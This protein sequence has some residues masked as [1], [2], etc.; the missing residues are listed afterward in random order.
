MFPFP[1]FPS[2]V[3]PLNV[4]L[5]PSQVPSPVFPLLLYLWNPIPSLLVLKM[6]K[7]KHRYNQNICILKINL[8]NKPLRENLKSV[9]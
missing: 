9:A 2:T 7:K 3:F 4:H 8:I 5:I 6:K 1:H